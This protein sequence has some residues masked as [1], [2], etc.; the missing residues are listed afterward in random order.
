MNILITNDDGWGF[1]GIKSLERIA[2]EFGDV[3]IVA[4][5]QPMSG[6]SHRM[7]FEVPMIFEERQPNS[8]ALGGDTCRLHARWIDATGEKIRLG[9]VR[10]Q[11]R[12][13][14]WNRPIR[15][16]HRCR[17]AR[18]DFV[19]LQR[20]RHFATPEKICRTLQLVKSRTADEILFRNVASTKTDHTNLV[21]RKLAGPR[22]GRRKPTQTQRH[23]SRP[24]PASRRLRAGRRRKINLSGPLQRSKT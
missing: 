13:Q 9:S 24:Q 17:G 19:W 5:D 21:Q 12:S 20:H 22:D 1:D 15:L 16:R 3:W 7:T 14:S 11:Q 8:F 23:H 6:I 18:S 10:D 4:P 2:R